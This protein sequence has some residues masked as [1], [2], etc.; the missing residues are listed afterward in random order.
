[1]KSELRNYSPGKSV[2]LIFLLFISTLL[3]SCGLFGPTVAELRSDTPEFALYAAKFNSSQNRYKI[4]VVFSKDLAKELGK[5][6]AAPALVIGRYLKSSDIRTRFQ[7]L[8][9]L[10]SELVINQNAFYSALLDL[11]NVEGRQ[12][13]LPVSFNLPLMAFD[14]NDEENRSDSFLLSFSEL[15]SSATQFNELKRGAYV[16]MGFGP[17]WSPRFLYDVARLYGT[18]FREADPLKWSKPGLDASIAYIQEW[19]RRANG[20]PEKEY[21]FSF[22]YLYTPGYKSVQEGRI[23]YA[24]M[25]S[26][27]FF[28]IAEE[29][30]ASLAFRWLGKDKKIPV[31]DDVV[32]AGICRGGKGKSAAEAFLKWFYS[33]ATQK[34]LLENS[35]QFRMMERSFGVAGG[36]SAIKSVNEKL[37]PLFYPTLLGK[38]P[39]AEYLVPSGILPANW[40]SL[41]KDV[42]LPFLLTATGPNPPVD[43]YGELDLRIKE[44]MKNRD[45][46]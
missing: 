3:N 2:S 38:L 40:V 5:D 36:F 46:E 13:L 33:E 31:E 4:Q 32:Y 41:K 29:N 15:E 6:S 39:P 8:D 23:K 19:I 18:D 7:S 42:I 45:E 10:F 28:T 26:S 44:W 11:G 12:I 14:K 21:D 34:M 27:S 25:E 35:R 24:A 1:M 22:K 30:R 20:S 9:Y 37:F 17:R 16:A 43:L